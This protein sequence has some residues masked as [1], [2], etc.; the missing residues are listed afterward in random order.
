M[1]FYYN[2][3]TVIILITILYLQNKY[4]TINREMYRLISVNESKVLNST[5]EL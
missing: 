3:V 1:I 4:R 2:L 5:N